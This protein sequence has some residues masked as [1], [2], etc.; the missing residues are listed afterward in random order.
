MEDCGFKG[1]SGL[2][3]LGLLERIAALNND[4]PPVATAVSFLTFLSQDTFKSA[5]RLMY[6][7]PIRS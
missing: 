4:R 1:G 6:S 5:Y 3:G 2:I 7:E